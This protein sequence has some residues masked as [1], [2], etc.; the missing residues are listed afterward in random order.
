MA[1]KE[2]KKALKEL[3]ISRMGM[4]NTSSRQVVD[5]L[6]R[7]FILNCEITV[8]IIAPLAKPSA[9]KTVA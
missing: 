9:N 1:R 6:V 5:S 8:A 2:K 7:K 4:R 3:S